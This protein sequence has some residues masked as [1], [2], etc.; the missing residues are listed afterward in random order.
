MVGRLPSNGL[1]SHELA[2]FVPEIVSLGGRTSHRL[3]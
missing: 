2:S 1:R 3:D